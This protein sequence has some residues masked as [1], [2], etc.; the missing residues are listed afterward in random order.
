MF[1]ELLAQP[2]VRET[3]ELG[4]SFGLMAF[5]GGLEGGTE[6]IAEQVAG[7]SGATVYVV[8]QPPDLTWHIP[9]ARVSPAHSHVL[10][11]FLDHVEVAVAIH[12]YGRP[13]RSLDLLL[14]GSNRALATHLAGALRRHLSGFRVIDDIVDIP[15]EL[16]GL[17]PNNPVNKPRNGGVQLELPPRVRGASPSRRDRGRPCLPLPGVVDALCEAANTW[18]AVR[19]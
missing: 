5:H 10:A 17:H 2:G 7:R 8:V 19:P 6:V 9:S 1:D 16:R 18:P 12:G 11:S 13:D 4:S 14:G 15:V 3:V